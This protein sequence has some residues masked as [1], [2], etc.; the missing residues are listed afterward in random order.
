M[1]DYYFGHW[2]LFGAW[3]LGIG[4]LMIIVFMTIFRFFILP[5]FS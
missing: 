5:S 2:Y 3:D 1:I 4:I